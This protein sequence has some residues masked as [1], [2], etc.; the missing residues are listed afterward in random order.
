MK[1]TPRQSRIK[2]TDMNKHKLI[3]Q[4]MATTF[5][6]GS[7]GIAAPAYAQDQAANQ[8]TAS[9]PVE[10]ANPSVSSE[11]EDVQQPRDIVITGSR[12]PQPNL[13]SA[14]PVTV[15]SAQE[16]KA[17]GTTRIED[18]VNQLP[19]TFAGQGGFVSNGSSGTATLNLRGLGSERT[20]VLVN[21]RRLLPG[22]PFSSA[23]DVNFIPAALVERV[24]V[25]TGGASSVYGSD[26]VAGVVNFIMDTDFEGIRLDTQYSFFN[27]D[28]NT[29]DS[30]RTALRARNFPFPGGTVADGGAIDATLVMGAG[31]DDGRGHVTAYAGYRQIDPVRQS[32]R[33]YSACSLTARTAA[34]IAIGPGAGGTS[35]FTCGGSATSANGT[36][37]TNFE[38]LQ[39]GPNRTLI[40]GS[41][42]FNFAPTNYYQRPDERYVLGAFADYEISS[43]LR[44]YM[45]VMFMDDRTVAQ[46]APSGVFFNNQGL[47]INCDNPLL[48]AQQRAILCAPNNLVRPADD[49][50]TGVDESATGPIAFIDQNGQ[51]YFRGVAYIGRR[52]VEGGPR[53]DDLQHTDFRIVTGLRGDLSDVWSYDAYYQYGRVNFAETYENDFSVTRVS[54]ALDVVAGPGGTPVCRSVLTGVDANC[55]PYNVFEL[56][57]V[58]PEALAYVQIPGFQRGINEE[59]VANAVITGNL[60]SYGMKFP[61]ADQGVG[62]AAGVEYRRE[63]VDLRTDVAFQTGDLAGQGA[64]TLPIKGDFDVKE[65]FGEVSI[66]IV[67]DSFIHNFT[68]AAGYRYSDY[69]VGQNS[70]STDTYK[71]EAEFAPIRDIRFRGSYNRA[72]RAPNIQDLFAT[73]RVALN[74]SSDPC[75]GILGDRLPNGQLNVA[76]DPSRSASDCARTGVTSGQYGN[77]PINPAQQFN[78]LIG[79]N[80][81]LIPE[82]ATTKTAGIVFQ[83]TFLRGFSA[84]VDFFDIKIDDTIQQIGQDTIIDTCL[85][86]GNPTFCSLIQR[87]ARGSLFL[88][89]NGFVRD[90]TQNIGGLSTRGVD[91]A[92]SYNREIGAFGTVGLSFIGTYLDELI[93]D[94]GVTDPYDCTGLYGNQCGTPN[95]EWR[96][97]AR[98]NF[99]TPDGIGASFRW[100]HYG[101]V[102]QDTLELGGA[103]Q[104][105]NARIPAQN[106]LDATLTFNI[107]DHYSFR[108]GA[109]N[110]LDR[111]PPLVG[112]QACPAGFCNGNTYPQVYDALGRYIFAGVTLDF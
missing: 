87:D 99:R 22:D 24:D 82:T 70:F 49:P 55:V 88:G 45:E 108:L 18:L 11:G 7:L 64:P 6:C 76:N 27:H 39:I 8:G 35:E 36:I 48:S 54:R 57:K 19:Q 16:V 102:R 30:V 78:G 75:E 23:A 59:T 74:G 84:T 103:T 112:A 51:P 21:G 32:R 56:N 26:A 81:N 101:A 71:F 52:N 5:I 90:L 110:I 91:V 80:P 72:V 83:P 33:D 25:L 13:E 77:I 106:Y 15:V 94:N 60:G 38:T 93:T 85:N 44:P 100:R 46:I 17:S 98:V 67:T 50:N 1:N 40:P 20:L 86:T 105:A 34:A 89:S 65:A 31:F 109:N 43:A 68:V 47:S 29:R 41:T 10:G 66:P 92:A 28:N 97:V 37:F 12:I 73:Q 4:L 61:W 63:A 53:R 79:G 9:G 2:G 14:S 107:G 104:P 111:D 62:L 42:P 3:N 69:S 96:H 58:T 95:P